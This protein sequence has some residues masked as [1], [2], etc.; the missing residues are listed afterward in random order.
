MTPHPADQFTNGESYDT[1]VAYNGTRSDYIRAALDYLRDC[2]PH[3]TSA[4]IKFNGE[5]IVLSAALAKLGV[6]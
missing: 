3:V 4:T 2:P 6:Q 1:E 5:V